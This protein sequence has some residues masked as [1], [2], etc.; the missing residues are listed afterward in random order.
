ML[1][2]KNAILNSLRGCDIFTRYSSSQYLLLIPAPN[3]ELITQIIN[4]IMEHYYSN[5]AKGT[6]EYAVR[7]LQG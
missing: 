3:A 4:R 1:Y 5:K 7:Q 6:I 2:L